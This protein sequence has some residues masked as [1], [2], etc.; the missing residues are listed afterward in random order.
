VRTLVANPLRIEMT[1]PAPRRLNGLKARVG[2]TAT[3]V[4]VQLFVPG[5][6]QARIFSVEVGETP[7]PREVDLPFDSEYE[8]QR[9]V[10]EVRSIND[11]E[12]AHVHLWEVK[13]R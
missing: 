12:P 5:E 8:V 11:G 7:D 4:S 9:L 2:G 3:E 6:D 1:F 10:L 13:F